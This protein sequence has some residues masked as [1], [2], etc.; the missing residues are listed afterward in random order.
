VGVGDGDVGEQ[1]YQKSESR[2]F[3]AVE[4]P[5]PQRALPAETQVGHPDEVVAHQARAVVAD[6]GVTVPLPAGPTK[7][8]MAST[9]FFGATT[10]RNLEQSTPAGHRVEL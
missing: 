2:D 1:V 10:R 7:A 3:V 6:R 9:P 4:A 8:I 5:Q